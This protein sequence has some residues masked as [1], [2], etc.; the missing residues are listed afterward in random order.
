MRPHPKDDKKLRVCE[1]DTSRNTFTVI[2]NALNVKKGMK[3]VFAVS[4][5]GGGVATVSSSRGQ[6]SWSGLW[7]A[8]Q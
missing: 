1:V 5:C 4:G 7:C 2:T 3:V 8:W 6:E